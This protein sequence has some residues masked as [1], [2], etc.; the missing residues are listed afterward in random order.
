MNKILSLFLFVLAINNFVYGQVNSSDATIATELLIEDYDYFLRVLQETPPLFHAFIDKK[1]FAAQVSSLR[2]A[3]DRPLTTREFNR[4]ILKTVALLNTMSVFMLGDAGFGSYLKYGGSS[5][6][7][8]IKYLSGNVYIGENFSL[9]DTLIRGTEII[10]INDIPT[11]SIIKELTS[12]LRVRPNGSISQQLSY[13]WADLLWLHYG[14][15]K[16]LRLSY[17]LP[18][19]TEIHTSIVQGVNKKPK[20]KK[21]KE[22]NLNLRI[23]AQRNIAVMSI[24][25]FYK[26]NEE[27]QSFL[28]SSFAK[29]KEDNI[30]NLVIDVREN[31]GLSVSFIPALMDYL[32]DKSYLEFSTTIVKSSKA[33]QECLTTHPAYVGALKEIRK[34]TSNY[35]N[36]ILDKMLA[37]EPGTETKVINTYTTPSDNKK[38]RFNGNLYVLT[39]DET[40]AEATTFAAVIKDN[41]LGYIIG[42]ETCDKACSYGFPILTELPNTRINIQIPATYV[43]RTAGYDDGRGVIPDFIVNATYSDYLK[44]NDKVM[45]YTYWLIGNNR[46]N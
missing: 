33:C 27:F 2:A 38:Y 42:E 14:F 45:N 6:P 5:F 35:L 20:A 17:I 11:H 7:F 16:E 4:V 9:N 30:E 1:E 19:D 3:I 37:N 34:D 36:I 12:Y 31:H 24:N 39:S 22:N 26:G 13:H 40:Y 43:I 21:V 25:R 44:G 32:T 8:T 28:D 29:I 15:N 46:N 23:D 10:A 41:K 18:N